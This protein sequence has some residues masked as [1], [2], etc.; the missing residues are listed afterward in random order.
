MDTCKDIEGEDFF[1]KLS[2]V[3]QTCHNK[4]VPDSFA[5]WVAH[6][7]IEAMRDGYQA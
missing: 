7:T 1:K 4:T 2:S 6:R 5:C 3:F